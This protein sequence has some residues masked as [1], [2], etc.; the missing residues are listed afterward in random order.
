MNNYVNIWWIL[1]FFLGQAGGFDKLLLDSLYEDDSA[2][3]QIELQKAGYGYGEMGVENNPF[4]QQDPFIMSNNIAPPPSVQM[5]MMAQ[6]Q[7]H[8]QHQQQHQSMM[9]VPY[10]YQ[11]QNPQPQMQ[12][13]SASNPFG[14]P[15]PSLPQN[16]MPQQGNHMLL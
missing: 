11:S 6:Q 14:D 15:F 1:F 10:Q 13:M 8:L 16:S 4:E 12:P 3:R 7:Y 2:R 5:A 9:M